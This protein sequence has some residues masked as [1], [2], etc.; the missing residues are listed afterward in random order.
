MIRGYGREFA[1]MSELRQYESQH[2]T[3]HVPDAVLRLYADRGRVP[4]VDEVQS[5]AKEL[6]KVRKELLKEL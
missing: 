6:L 1:S 3:D 2:K 4:A 5:M